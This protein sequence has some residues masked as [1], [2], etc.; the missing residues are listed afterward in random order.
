MQITLDDDE[1][2][3]ALAKEIENKL[4]GVVCDID[5]EGCWFEVSAG[6]VEGDKVDDIHDVKFC[7]KGAI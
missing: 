4:D 3:A 6:S 7:F 1:I 5:P 2:R